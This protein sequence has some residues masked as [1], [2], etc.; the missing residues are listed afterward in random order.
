M[1]FF[2]NFLFIVMMVDGV[3]NHNSERI[4]HICIKF[5]CNILYVLFIDMVVMMVGRQDL[6][7]IVFEIKDEKY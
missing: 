5:N 7:L 1:N 6:S 4:F 3:L 2:T